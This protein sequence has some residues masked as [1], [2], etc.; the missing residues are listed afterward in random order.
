MYQKI[1]LATDGSVPSE[2]AVD[3]AT[4][5]A[6]EQGA[7]LLILHVVDIYGYYLAGGGVLDLLR[8]QG[9][10]ILGKAAARAEALGVS[11]TSRLLE[12]G[13]GGHRVAELISQEGRSWGADLIVLGTHGRRGVDHLLFGSVAEGVAR[14]AESSVLLA[15]GK[16][17][18]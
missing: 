4:Q 9:Q 11:F 10:E 1:L 8:A 14:L 13:V 17:L 5:L 6:A 2:A 18:R 12:T 16:A 7:A 15:R 3:A